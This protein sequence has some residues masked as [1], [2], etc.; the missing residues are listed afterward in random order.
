MARFT[1]AAKIRDQKGKQAAKK[2]RGENQLPAIFY[3]SGASSMMLT[4]DYNEL[5]KI[6]TKTSGENVIIGLQIESDK[7]TDSKIV[8]IKDLQ[9]DPVKR[10]YLHADF[11]EISMD[12]ELEVEIALHFVN[13]PKG[14]VNGGMLQ[15]IRRE[16]AVSCLP[17]KLVDFI[18]IDVSGLDIGESLH[19]REIT[20]PGGINSLMDPD[21]PVVTVMAPSAAAVEAA[22]GEGKAEAAEGKEK[23][24]EA[25]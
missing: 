14:V 11:Y 19:I 10:N 2:L 12:K 13:V 21:L 20:L 24:T 9:S 3:G 18:E 15:P 4:V 8:I 7:G 16:I 5:N 6:I 23:A 17:D 22:A 1:L 25:K